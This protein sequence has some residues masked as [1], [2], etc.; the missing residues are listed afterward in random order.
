MAGG[1]LI[2]DFIVRLKNG[3]QAE[4]QVEI[5]ILFTLKIKLYG[6][7]DYTS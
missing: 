4:V 7:E 3:L 6:R 2:S 1:H 5:E